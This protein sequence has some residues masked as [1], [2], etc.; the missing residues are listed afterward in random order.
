MKKVLI[1]G[2]GGFIG[3][4][5]S[6]H[7]TGQYKIRS[8]VRANPNIFNNQFIEVMQGDWLDKNLLS[9]ALDQV[10][11]VI[12]LIS[13]TVPST[14][15]QNPTFDVQTNL[16]GSLQLFEMMIQ[17]NVH[18]IIY[19][20][21][22]GAIYGHQDSNLLSETVL[23]KP[24]SSYAVVKLAIENYL[25]IFSQQF[26]LL[27]TILRVSN[28]YGIRSNKIGVQGLIPT[29]FNQ[30]L[31]NEPIT[32]W[33]DGKNIRDY[34]YIDDL[35]RAIQICIDQEHQGVFNIGSG[36]GQSSLDLIKLIENL[37]DIS[38]QL[39]FEPHRPFDVDR[40]VLDC[41]KA[42]SILHWEPETSINQGLA[43]YWSQLKARF[44]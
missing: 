7:L 15:N 12:H 3:G 6:H 40:V 32:L 25:S 26:G 24:I 43:N 29:V 8:L 44:K 22:G 23:P 30:L 37:T 9:S 21:S 41:T 27:P 34:I 28:P 33:G 35:M 5:L 36:V 39:R 19:L 14:S 38:A 31:V 42:K 20:S 13:T 4:H 2:G 18:R 11:V 10:D 17:K 16:I 1:L